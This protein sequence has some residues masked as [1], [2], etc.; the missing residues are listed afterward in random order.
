MNAETGIKVL[1]CDVSVGGQNN[2]IYPTLI[3]D[4]DEIVLVDAGYPGQLDVIES[5][6]HKYGLSAKQITKVIITH[7]DIDHIGC[8]KEISN[9]GARIYAHEIETPYIQG[10][11]TPVKLAKMESIANSLPPDRMGFY[12]MMKNTFP[13]LYVHVDEQLKDKQVLP[14]CGGIVVYHTPGHTP[15]HIALWHKESKTLIAGDAANISDGKLVNPNPMQSDNA[16]QSAASLERIKSLG[17]KMIICYHSGLM[18][19]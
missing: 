9:M 7:Q 18:T 19:L 8:A 10:E 5:E 11:K 13:K 15:G 6:M 14:F 2:T 16:E 12:N 3:I 17:A 1:K 4:K